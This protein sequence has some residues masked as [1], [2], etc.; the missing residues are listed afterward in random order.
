MTSSV[1]TAGRRRFRLSLLELLLIG[2]ILA[3]LVYLASLW[4]GREEVRDTAVPDQGPAPS[5]LTSSALLERALAASDKVQARL[6]SLEKELQALGRRVEALEKTLKAGGGKAAKG[7]PALRRRL[8]A[9]EK[10][11]KTL[12]RGKAAAVDLTPLEAR[13]LF[14]EKK[15]GDKPSHKTIDARLAALERR[16]ARSGAVQAEEARLARRLDKLEQTAATRRELQALA[17][18]LAQKEKSPPGAIT[19]GPAPAA[20]ALQESRLQRLESGLRR[21][22][23]SLSRV[24][25][26]VPDP[27]VEARLARL[28]KRLD[29]LGRVQARPPGREADALAGLQ[30]RLAALEQRVRTLARSSRAAAVSSPARPPAKAKPAP[31]VHKLYHKVRRGQTLYAIARRY[32]VKVSQIKDWNPKLKRRRH[33]WVGETLVIYLKR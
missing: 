6:V 18:R 30:R 31:K 8:A 14:L 10:R 1:P 17:K 25:A 2:L 16:L 21:M 26:P 15:V 9:L 29:A 3:V 13:V 24:R 20:L 28:E 27:A 12:S 19:P 33:L 5:A 32:G 22:Q 11:L 7:D 23:V 4:L